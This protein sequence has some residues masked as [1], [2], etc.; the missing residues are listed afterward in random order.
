MKKVLEK[1]KKYRMLIVGGL[2]IFGGG[3]YAATIGAPNVSFFKVSFSH[4]SLIML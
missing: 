2:I 4:L 3:V 1:V